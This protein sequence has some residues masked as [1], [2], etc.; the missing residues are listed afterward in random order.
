MRLIS[1]SALGVAALVGCLSSPAAALNVSFFGGELFAQVRGQWEG[2]EYLFIDSSPLL[3][4]VPFERS[5]ETTAMGSPFIIRFDVE[6][7][8]PD[9]SQG[10]LRVKVTPIS[11]LDSPA[12]ITVDVFQ[13][14]LDVA[15]D[16]PAAVAFDW[17]VMLD[18]ISPITRIDLG[19]SLTGGTALEFAPGNHVGATTFPA[20]KGRRDI[21]VSLDGSSLIPPIERIEGPPITDIGLDFRIAPVMDP[22]PGGVIPEPGAWAMLIAGFG[23]VGGA[24]RTRRRE[25]VESGTAVA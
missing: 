18:P 8:M 3:P 17:Q 10:G 25:A 6:F 2:E 22:P 16:I 21:I 15:T 7:F 11:V 4:G 24:L 14:S 20:G 1:G 12:L 13:F 9:A 23:L 5:W 19:D